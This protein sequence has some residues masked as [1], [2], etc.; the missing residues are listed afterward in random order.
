MLLVRCFLASYL[1][2]ELAFLFV[3]TVYLTFLMF[4][5]LLLL[6]V[7]ASGSRYISE[8]YLVVRYKVVLFWRLILSLSLRLLVGLKS[9]VRFV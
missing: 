4:A 9:F 1:L 2:D 8:N 7:E 3:L 6:V 5:G